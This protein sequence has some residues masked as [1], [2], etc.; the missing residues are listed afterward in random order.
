[1]TFPRPR[2][3]VATGTVSRAKAVSRTARPA[4]ALAGGALN[5]P[6]APLATATR[7]SLGRS[8]PSPSTSGCAGTHLSGG[9][10]QLSTGTS[11]EGRLGGRRPV[12]TLSLASR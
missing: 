6:Q 9:G 3:R 5:L 4:L 10:I 7:N 1:M 12:L 11:T 8:F 2:A